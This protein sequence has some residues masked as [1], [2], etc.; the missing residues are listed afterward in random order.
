MVRPVTAANTLENYLEKELL[1]GDLDRFAGVPIKN[2]LVAGCG[3]GRHSIN[4]ARSFPDA[5]VL[6]VDISRASLWLR[7]QKDA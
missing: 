5:N 3:T 7:D 4:V 6:A 2:I 1:R